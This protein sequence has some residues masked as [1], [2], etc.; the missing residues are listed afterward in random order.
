M[1]AGSRPITMP[2]DAWH[3]R[4]QKLLHLLK[5]FPPGRVPGPSLK[6]TFAVARSRLLF[7]R[8]RR[9]REV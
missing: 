7:R 9:F 4:F 5:V 6:A 1:G 2:S 3:R 8:V